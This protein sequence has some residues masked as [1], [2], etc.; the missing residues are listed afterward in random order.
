MGEAGADEELDAW[1][2]SVG[3]ASGTESRGRGGHWEARTWHVGFRAKR[4]HLPPLRNRGS[5]FS[6]A[7]APE[8]ICMPPGLSRESPA[9][10]IRTCSRSPVD[11]FNRMVLSGIPR[12]L[13]RREAG[14]ESVSLA[15]VS[16][17]RRRS[18]FSPP[19]A[20]NTKPRALLR[21]ADMTASPQLTQSQIHTFG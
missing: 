16:R 14:C 21:V 5:Y 6:T 11:Y 15:E 18:T 13:I 1:A 3:F 17:L 7:A 2:A 10:T 4:C 9:T 19:A 8:L 20:C 12:A